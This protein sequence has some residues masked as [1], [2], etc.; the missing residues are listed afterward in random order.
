VLTALNT[1]LRR[2]E[3]FHLQWRDVDFENKW[4]TVAGSTAK[5]GQTRRIPLN[6]EALVT[7]QGWCQQTLKTPAEPRVF[8]GVG[9]HRLTSVNRSWRGLRKL[10]ALGDFRFHDLRHHFASRL[11]QSGIDLNTVRELLG[12]ADIT[13]VLRY[14]HLSP[15]RLVMA[16]Q[17]VARPPADLACRQDY[18]EAAT[19]PFANQSIGY[20]YLNLIT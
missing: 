20:G 7:L 9:G 12:H 18:P 19:S 3:L 6:A 5:S 15:D 2:G 10:A 1:G 16:V 17:K 8:P 4:L 14:A 13:M 11:V